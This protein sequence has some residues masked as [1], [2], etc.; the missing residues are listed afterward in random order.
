MQKYSQYEN[1]VFIMFDYTFISEFNINQST[2]L[3]QDHFCVKQRHND[4]KDGE[5]EG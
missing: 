3:A 4:Q 2:F 1:N 5:E